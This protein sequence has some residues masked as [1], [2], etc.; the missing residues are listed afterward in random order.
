VS[1]HEDCA[2]LAAAVDGVRRV[3]RSGKGVH[4][5]LADRLTCIWPTA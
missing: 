4:L 3:T 1:E 5:H 2:P